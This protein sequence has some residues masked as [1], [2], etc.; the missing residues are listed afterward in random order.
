[1]LSFEDSHLKL[2]VIKTE[3]FH[4][5]PDC[6]NP[7][8][9]VNAADT[10]S[11]SGVVGVNNLAVACIH[12]IMTGIVYYIT[13]LGLCQA[14]TLAHTVEAHPRHIV[15]E[16]AV[17][18]ID[19]PGAVGPI[20]EACSPVFIRISHKLLAVVHQLLAVC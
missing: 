10:D 2:P 16:M 18:G 13:R 12:G 1:M 6:E 3:L 15:T 14:H 7:A 4:E 5:A 17:Y 19:E 8:G 9:S 11:G 20:C